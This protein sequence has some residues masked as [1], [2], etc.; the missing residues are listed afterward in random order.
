MPSFFFTQQQNIEILVIGGK[1]RGGS[2]VETLVWMKALNALGNKI[3]QAKM[4][5]ETR[6]IKEE[7]SW[8]NFISTYHPEKF[9]KRLVWLTYRLPKLFQAIRRSNC[10]YVYTS[11]PFWH[12][13]FT[14]L[15]CKFLGIKH[16][17]RIA[18]DKNVNFDLDKTLNSL[19]K[20]LIGFS[21]GMADYI[22]VQNDFQYENLK[23]EFPKIK[24]FKLF[25][26]IEIKKD[27]LNIKKSKSGYIAWVAN[28]RFQ[29]NLK[30]LY[31]IA[32]SLPNEMFKIAGLALLPM[33]EETD[34]YIKKL[35]LLQNV[36]FVGV[37]DQSEIPNFLTQAKF[38]LNTSRY[39]GF[40]NTFLEAMMVGLPILTT[41]NVNPDG[42]IDKNNLGI[43]YNDAWDLS[44]K[45]N[46]LKDPE[47]FQISKCCI[48]YI[49]E[50][51]DHIT[52]GKNLLKY[53][54]IK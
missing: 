18:N 12:T 44:L 45:I 10:D 40:S 21:Y 51:H 15:M 32:F 38:L 29:K 39:E 11:I 50:N 22:F 19:D 8:V 13:F 46:K 4:D 41:H 5:G 26:P 31:E 23:L 30:L 27:Y 43:L 35:K 54:E 1:P 28:F 24:I 33:D 2:V 16:I 3:F 6:E 34:T 37:L 7:Y 42:I 52:I 36:E 48:M 47:Y 14:G 9:K 20:K 17:I 53:L 49:E 25:N